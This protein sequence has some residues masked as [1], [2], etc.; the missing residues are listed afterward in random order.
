VEEL[1]DL[2]DNVELDVR[3]DPINGP[4]MQGDLNTQQCQHCQKYLNKID[5]LME[6]IRSCTGEK[7]IQCKQCPKKFITSTI[8]YVHMSTHTVERP[9]KCEQ[10]GKQFS[11]KSGLDYHTTRYHGKKSSKPLLENETKTGYNKDITRKEG[12][13]YTLHD[14]D[15]IIKANKSNPTTHQWKP[16]LPID[17]IEIIWVE[18]HNSDTNIGTTA[19]S[20]FIFFKTSNNGYCKVYSCEHCEKQF[21]SQWELRAHTKTH[22]GEVRYQCHLCDKHSYNSSLSVHMRKHSGEKPFKCE[23]CQKQFTV[24]CDLN[25]N[26]RSHTGEKPFHCAYCSKQFS[27]SSN[28]KSH[29]R[30]HTGRGV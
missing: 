23:R 6:H 21:S 3:T 8:L 4:R 17:K 5:N 24:K 25:V 2:V 1:D 10:C 16:S 30:I 11:A 9:F 29:T 15:K 7:P 19:T 13:P 27:T 18:N 20:S 28:L 26:M 12:N 14:K 22:S